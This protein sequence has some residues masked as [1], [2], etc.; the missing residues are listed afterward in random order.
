[1]YSYVEPGK[2]WRRS[3][4][5]RDEGALLKHEQGHFD[6]AELGVRTTMSLPEST[7]PSG[8]GQSSEAASADIKGKM[9]VFREGR[10]AEIR[11]LQTRYDETT[12]HSRIKDVQEKWNQYLEAKLKNPALQLAMPS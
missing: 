4:L 2:C 12:N 9:R 8:W 6:I 7:Y 10:A 1:M 3:K 5:P 11:D